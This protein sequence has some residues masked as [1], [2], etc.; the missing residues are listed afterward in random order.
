MVE[1]NTPEAAADFYYAAHKYNCI[2]AL[3]FI[4]QYML[5]ELNPE[6]AVVFYADACL[7][8]NRELREACVKIFSD[9]TFDVINSQ[10]FLR[11]EPKIVEAIYKLNAL[12]I[13]SEL[14]LINALE[15]YIDHN[16]AL[17]R[18]IVEQVRPALGH[19]RFLTIAAPL[20]AQTTL[21]KSNDVVAVVGC[22]S[23]DAEL[24]KMPTF[25][26]SNNKKRAFP[27][28]AMKMVRKLNSWYFEKYCP[29]C[30]SAY[31]YW[32]CPSHSTTESAM[33]LKNIYQK[34][35]H[36]WL[37]DYS[38]DDLKAVYEVFKSLNYIK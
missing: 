18:D 32:T 27:D 1:F 36:V 25:L 8:E 3:E 14:Q 35:K 26:S 24:C 34:Y 7:Y 16:Q 4:T 15:R 23:S 31:A 19:I 30:R 6:N 33:K 13:T 5:K 20:V 17:I 38:L 37:L 11:A 22:L 10:T 12:S 21:L 29:A 2:D 9:H 28:S